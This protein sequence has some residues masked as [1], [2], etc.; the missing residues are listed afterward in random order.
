MTYKVRDKVWLHLKNITIDRLYKKLDW[1]HAK[2]T[3]MKVFPN[4]HIYKLNVP[5]G[6][7]KKFHTLLLRPAAE[8]PLPL[9]VQDNSQPSV[10]TV[11]NK[12]KWLVEKILYAKWVKRG[13]GRQRVALVKWHGFVKPTW[14]PIIKLQKTAALDEYK[15][16]YGAIDKNDGP[17]DKYVT[18][19]KR[20]TW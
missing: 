18:T 13:R 5:R 4:K 8:D 7:Y 1:L 11:D 14:E 9:Q 20:Y 17:L 10:I 19:E 2:Y 12:E 15:K 3:V 6:V 16:E